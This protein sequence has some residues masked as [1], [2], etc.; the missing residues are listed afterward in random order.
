MTRRRSKRLWKIL[1]VGLGVHR[2]QS[3][4]KAMLRRINGLVLII[5]GVAALHAICDH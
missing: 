4:H 3:M 2:T 5:I 1:A